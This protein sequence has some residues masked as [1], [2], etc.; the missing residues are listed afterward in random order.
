M[1]YSEISAIDLQREIDRAEYYSEDSGTAL[2]EAVKEINRIRIICQDII[3]VIG[4]EYAQ[5][6]NA[7]STLSKIDDIA[8]KYFTG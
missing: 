3:E 6:G 4:V 5:F 7:D 8:H 1:K 2:F